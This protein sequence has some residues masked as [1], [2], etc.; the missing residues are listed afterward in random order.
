MLRLILCYSYQIDKSMFHKIKKTMKIRFTIL[1]VA[2]NYFTTVAGDTRVYR[3]FR[4]II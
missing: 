2:E 1:V 4:E 3:I